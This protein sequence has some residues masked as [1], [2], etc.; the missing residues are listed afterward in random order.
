M[1]ALISPPKSP[2]QVISPTTIA[3]LSTLG[4]PSRCWYVLGF[5]FFFWGIAK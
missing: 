3:V 1:A 5:R 4:P 2:K